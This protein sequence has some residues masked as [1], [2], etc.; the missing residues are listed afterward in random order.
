MSDDTLNKAL[1]IMGYDT[2]PGGDHCAYCF[3]STASTL[4]NEGRVRRRCSGSPIRPQHGK[5][6]AARRGGTAP[7]WHG[8]K[9]K[10]LGIYKPLLGRRAV[11]SVSRADIEAFMHSVAE[12]KAATRVKTGKKRGLSVVR[13]GT[14]LP[15]G[16]SACWGLSLRMR[17]VAGFEPIIQCAVLSASLM[18]SASG[19]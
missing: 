3:R 5:K 9:N 6:P 1:R 10:I 19:A 11:S 15:R 4:L 12:G 7:A 17:F 8:D 2:G 18:V 14:V 13:G 16:P